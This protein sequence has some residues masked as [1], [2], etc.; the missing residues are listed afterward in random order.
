[1]AG[2][3]AGLALRSLQWFVRFI[4]FGCAAVILGIFSYFLSALHNHHYH[5]GA[6]VKAVEGISGIAVL[7]TFAALALLCCL[8]GFTVTSAF[9]ILLDLAFIGCFIFVAYENRN[10]SDSCKGRVATPFGTGESSDKVPSNGG[11]FTKLPTYGTACKLQTAALSV[12]I[13]AW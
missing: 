3:A 6:R 2:K 7:Y 10:G 4:Q 9:A 11:G 8:A 5:I 1:M 13:V 12:A